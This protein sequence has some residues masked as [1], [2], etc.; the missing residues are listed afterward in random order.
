MNFLIERNQLLE[1]LGGLIKANPEN[2]ILI[3]LKNILYRQ[4][5]ILKLDGALSRAIVDSLDIE[6]DIGNKILSFEQ[7]YKNPLNVVESE[8]LKKVIKY[9]INKK[10]TINFIG[11][12]WS[13]VDSVWI[14]FD[15]I[16]NISKLREKLSLSD[17]I[18]EHKNTD[19][20]SGLELGFIDKITNEG[21]MGNFKI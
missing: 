11:K 2:E 16:L 7:Y 18:I 19:P 17:N 9:L 1:K 5:S 21:V 12:A 13:N 10:I 20:R 3:S 14:Y 15:T 4:D 8:E 6:L